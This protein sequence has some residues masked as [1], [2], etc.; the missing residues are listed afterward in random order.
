MIKSNI[1]TMPVYVSTISEKMAKRVR[2]VSC[3]VKFLTARRY[4]K[5]NLRRNA[6]L[7]FC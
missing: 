1:I 4:Q 3:G 7:S 6:A 2:D 5:Y